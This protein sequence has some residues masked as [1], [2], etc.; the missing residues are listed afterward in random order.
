MLLK[1]AYTELPKKETDSHAFKRF[2]VLSKVASSVGKPVVIKLKVE[3]LP[4]TEMCGCTIDRHST[5]I[6]NIN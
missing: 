2:Q 6:S 3:G 4:V 1:S 5:C